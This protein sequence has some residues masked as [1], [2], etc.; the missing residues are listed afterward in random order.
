MKVLPVLFF[1]FLIS[2]LYS[3][4]PLP[5]L[6]NAYLR[7]SLPLDGQWHY[8]VDPYETGY[9]NH[10]NW[11]PFDSFENKKASANPYWENRIPADRT[12]RI[13]YDFENSA[14]LEVPGDWN[15]QR[16]EL[17]YYEGT[18]WYQRSFTFQPKPEKRVLLYFGAVNYRADVYLNG[19]KVGFHEGGFNPFNFDVTS[20]L[21]EGANTL[22]VRA[23]NR[24]LA[25]RV[26]GL[27]F[28]WWNFG[29]ITRSVKL[30]ELPSL[31]IL[32]YHIQID[33]QNP[34][35][36][37]GYLQLSEPRRKEVTL[38]I[39]EANILREATTDEAGRAEF[40]FPSSGLT[41]WYPERPKLYSVLLSAGED[42]VEDRVGFRTIE[43]R[44][45]DLLLNGKSLF[46]RGICMHEENPLK[47]GRMHSESEARMVLGWARELNAN[48]LRLTHYPHN[49]H[50][51]RLA[52]KLGFL[53]WEEVPVYWGIDYAS[54][55]TFDQA[56]R[57]IQALVHRD[58]N[59]A[60]V[61]I[62][63]LANETPRED[64]ERLEFLLKMK[65]AVT[66]I[67]D[68]RLIS[69]ALDHTE[70]KERNIVRITDP[71]AAESDLV[72]ANEYIG[73]YGSMPDR[74]PKISWDVN[75]HEKPF[76][77]SEFG[78]G[79]KYNFR[80]DSL[81]RWSEEHQA[82]MY[83]ETLAM[84][85]KIP[86]LRGATP[87]LLFDFR[88]PRRNLALIQDQW[89]RKGIISDQGQKK[90]AFYVLQEYYRRKAEEY[91]YEMDD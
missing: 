34:D 12:E 31:Y 42:R 38:S 7:P 65:Q 3:Q 84:L 71:F 72:A 89:N 86:S 49:E 73:W 82:W 36:V 45:T 52:D 23:D 48:F 57:Q 37:A 25:S 32:D 79:A 35:R 83:R 28:D 40:S 20:L 66:E 63:S 90:R 18:L 70:D 6:Q 46:L 1:V 87:W 27:T 11:K 39:P 8:I 58:K 2:P 54:A 56:A 85:E 44:G 50:L 74:I 76:I 33:A 59:R 21:R 53:L 41:R 78:A 9:R 69:A 17:L 88:S 4:Q 60:S 16:P 10:R 75:E 15:H 47:G 64:P 22:I 51:P 67:E 29:G 30:I 68:D 77:I 19:R 5:L 14:T 81:T 62:W 24:R 13:E 61:I 91:R 80:G 26:P 43:T 55:E